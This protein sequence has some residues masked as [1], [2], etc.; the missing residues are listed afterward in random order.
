MKS[1]HSKRG[2]ILCG[3]LSAIL[4]VMPWPAN[5][6]CAQGIKVNDGVKLSKNDHIYFGHYKHATAISAPEEGW[7]KVSVSYEPPAITPILWRVMGKEGTDN[8]L[9]LMSEYVLDT[10]TFTSASGKWEDSSVRSW[11]NGMGTFL[12]GFTAQE[13]VLIKTN[14]VFSPVY[15]PI[16]TELGSLDKDP[17]LSVNTFSS[18]DK[19]YLPWG[20]P[21]HTHANG[22]KMFW[23]LA[24]G[25]IS[26][27][28]VL[29]R[30]AGVKSDGADDVYYWLRT[31]LKDEDMALIIDN[32]GETSLQM[33]GLPMGVRPVFRLDT[34]QVIF[35]TEVM[36]ETELNRLD[37]MRADGNY[38]GD[39]GLI[40]GKTTGGYAYK[41]TVLDSANIKLDI[42]TLYPNFDLDEK[43]AG[44]G[45]EEIFVNRDDTVW[46]GRLTST[47]DR[48]AY[49]LVDNSGEVM[50]YD[51]AGTAQQIGLA[52]K[53]IYMDGDEKAAP[54]S[55]NSYAAYIWAQKDNETQSHRG[56]MP[57]YFK[58]TV[59]DDD[60][61]PLLSGGSAVR[62]YE[63]AHGDT[64]KV[65]FLIDE[66]HGGKYYYLVQD[67]ATAP[68][69]TAEELITNA[70]A[71]AATSGGDPL[72]TSGITA[73][74]FSC[75]KVPFTGTGDTI[76]LH[77]KNNTKPYK[78]YIAAKDKVRNVSNMLT[79]LIPTYVPNT[80]PVANTPDPEF[81]LAVKETLPL[82]ATDIAYDPDPTDHLIITDTVAGPAD[83]IATVI[84]A[85]G[86]LEITGVAPGVTTMK[87]EVDDQSTVPPVHTNSKDTVTVRIA[88]LESIPDAELDYVDETLPNL[89]SGHYVIGADTVEIQPGADTCHLVEKWIGATLSIRRV[90]PGVPAV[91][92]QPQTLKIPAR[93][94]APE[95]N[96][97]NESFED[98]NDGWVTGVSPAMEYMPDTVNAGWTPV[99][100]RYIDNLPAGDYLIRSRAVPGSQF[101]GAEVR[102]TVQ[103]GVPRAP[104]NPIQRLV[105]LPDVKEVTMS[106]PAGVHV[107]TSQSDFPFTL[108]FSGPPSYVRTSRYID[109]EQEV[110]TGVANATGGYD[111]VIRSVQTEVAVYISPSTGL[112]VTEAERT[113]WAGG[114]RVYVKTEREDTA[115]IYGLS[116][117]VVRRAEVPG[118]TTS[119]PLHAGVYVVTLEESG[120]KQKVIIRR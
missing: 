115:V 40:N 72:I 66:A 61:P 18:S 83:S 90:Q 116:G 51:T 46:I 89:L 104:A 47:G 59:L 55:P 74:P 114:D 38:L 107:V 99:A 105:S 19:F 43:I 120:V 30:G 109:G 52:A 48:I 41:L 11:L 53:N 102:A 92:S 58:L 75:G 76:T 14:N 15:A 82:E 62:G 119:I 69:A 100:D 80:P 67:T 65:T 45:G 81:S 113:V 50:R 25:T 16:T 12:T 23:D 86:K 117:Q 56:S 84:L 96:A 79:V 17:Q 111:Y 2:T 13:Q 98:Y 93:P 8:A 71:A 26:A 4:W 28:S 63:P 7:H 24:G 31:T 22:N 108:K 70:I 21:P 57:K 27:D 37:Q 64:A 73:I 101:V 42:D 33:M 112:T 78:I 68:P 103:K 1:N 6:V 5:E 39:D 106:P 77:F 10:C 20:T 49:K 97:V 118:G 34:A 91:S 35:A 44:N 94:D 88:V 29:E 110:L 54:L 9:T 60:K 36:E 95:V 85:G 3:L 32:T 87:V